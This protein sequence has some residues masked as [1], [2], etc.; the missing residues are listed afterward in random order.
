M[1]NYFQT[2]IFQCSKNYGSLARVTRV[3]F[4]PYITDPTSMNYSLSSLNTKVTK[5]G[6]GVE[7]YSIGPSKSFFAYFTTHVF[8]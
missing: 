1:V 3:K 7:E 5:R 8:L 2:T 4:A 6:V